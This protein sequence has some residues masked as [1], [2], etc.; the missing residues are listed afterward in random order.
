MG[1]PLRKTTA[2]GGS[3]VTTYRRSTQPVCKLAP[4]NRNKQ[5][6]RRRIDV[7]R[8]CRKADCGFFKATASAR[9]SMPMR[10]SLGRGESITGLPPRVKTGSP[11]KTSEVLNT[12]EVFSGS[13]EIRNLSTSYYSFFECWCS[14]Q[15]RLAN[16][17]PGVIAGE[18][19]RQNR[20]CQHDRCWHSPK[21]QPGRPCH[22]P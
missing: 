20:S 14:I 12:A 19:V 8:Q 3:E 17:A 13:F 4:N 5:P 15:A 7:L 2:P 1:V 6:A 21:S 9:K 22:T 11:S 10:S 16:K 18:W